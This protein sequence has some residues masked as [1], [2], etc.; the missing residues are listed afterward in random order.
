M[1]NILNHNRN[2][3]DFMVSNEDYWDFQLSC[4]SGYGGASKGLSERCLSSYVDFNDSECVDGENVFS[5]SEYVWKESVNNGATLD[6]IGVT[7][8]DNG[9][10]R[11]E[12]D[13]ITNKEFLD[14]Y[15]NSSYSIIENDMRLKLKSVSGNNQIYDYSSNIV[16]IDGVKAVELNGGFYQGFFKAYGKDYQVLPYVIENGWSIE[17]VLRKSNLE[18]VKT[19]VNDTHKENKGMFLYIGT[20]AENK[21]WEKYKTDEKFGPSPVS[22]VGEGYTDET[23]VTEDSDVNEPYVGVEEREPEGY[24]DEVYSDDD[25]K[26][27]RYSCGKFIEEDYFVSDDEYCSNYFDEEYI[28][29][30]TE[31]TGEEQLVTS[32]GFDFGQPNIFEYD[33]DNKFLLF[34]RTPDGYT[35]KTW[36][37]GT[38]VT[39][40]DIRK[41]DIGNYHLL[42]NRT[43]DGMTVNNIEELIEADNKRYSVLND[44]YRNAI[45]FQIKDDGSIGYKYMVRDC[46]SEEEKYKIDERFSAPGII[47]NDKWHTVSIKILPVANKEI[48]NNVCDGLKTSSSEE[49]VIFIYVDGKLKMRSE[50]IPMINLKAL[51]DLADKQQGVP[52]SISVGGGTQ[53]LCDVID[54]DYRKIPKYMLPLEK[55]F[56]G[57]FIGY[58]RSFRFYSCPLEFNEIQENFAF[59]AK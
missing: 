39:M 45:A 6:Y 7:G 3:F 25:G 26:C 57:T 14:L 22:Y 42:F 17:V 8:V 4:E 50:Q 58:I 44:L 53:G 20:R 41:P 1:G 5:K 33:T 29:K 52:F 16:D 48:T 37:E 10:V 19:T 2:L 32:E 13:R 12:K 40:Y 15:L 34:N 9:F 21:W 23:Y 47:E 35:V 51:D 11:Y 56:C 18:N 36:E 55:E 38:V 49:M 46:E 30:D 24:L 31:I 43:P 54:I 59:D 28:E 27:C